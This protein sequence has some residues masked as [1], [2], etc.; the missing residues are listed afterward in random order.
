MGR[1]EYVKIFSAPDAGAAMQV[2]SVARSIPGVRAEITPLRG[3][4]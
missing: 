3:G 2:S 4:W 1:G